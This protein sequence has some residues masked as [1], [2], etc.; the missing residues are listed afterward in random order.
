MVVVILIALLISLLV[1]LLGSAIS[2]TL[3]HRFYNGF[4][5]VSR[6]S[7]EALVGEYMGCPYTE[8]SN[9]SHRK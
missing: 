2:V 7:L 8:S 5:N 6:V 3:H 9:H 4:V 1:L